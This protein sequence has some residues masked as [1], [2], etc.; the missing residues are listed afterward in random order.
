M[1]PQDLERLVDKLSREL[2]AATLLAEKREA[3]F[4]EEQEAFVE[5]LNELDGEVTRLAREV[6]RLNAELAEGR[7]RN[8]ALQESLLA[9]ASMQWGGRILHRN[10]H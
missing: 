2:E 10:P 4:V 3:E 8:K 7:A 5:E 1:N 9:K 6:S